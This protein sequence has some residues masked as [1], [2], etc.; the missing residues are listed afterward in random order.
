M[1]LHI[2]WQLV[3]VGLA[4]AALGVGCSASDTRVEG[5]T[6][7]EPTA[8]PSELSAF[9]RDILED[10]HVDFSEYREATLRTIECIGDAGIEGVSILG[11][12]P[13]DSDPVY[14]DYWAQ[15]EE[16]AI[17]D[18]EVMAKIDRLIEECE[19]EFLLAVSSVWR[20]QETSD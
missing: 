19:E 6:T 18:K 2:R 15:I 3:L 11:P 10:G 13:T 8:Y 9:Q 5:V 14:L 20:S 17:D 1:N 7:P 12:V 16:P 4:T